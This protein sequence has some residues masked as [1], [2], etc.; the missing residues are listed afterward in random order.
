MREQVWCCGGL[1]FV[2]QVAA[3]VG[4]DTTLDINVSVVVGSGIFFLAIFGD[5]SLERAII[6]RVFLRNALGVSLLL[7]SQDYF[8]R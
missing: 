6:Y 7:S 8:P 4:W 3:R 2:F 5:V 1:S